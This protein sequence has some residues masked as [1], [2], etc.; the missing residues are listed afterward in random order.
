M[1]ICLDMLSEYEK[2]ACP[3]LKGIDPSRMLL[4]FLIFCPS[5]KIENYVHVPRD[6]NF[7]VNEQPAD[8]VIIYEPG[9][10]LST[11]IVFTLGINRKNS[12]IR[13]QE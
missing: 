7:Y 9:V 3:P 6:A 13:E 8:W 11:S 2:I 1:F 12:C 10:Y 5:E 4:N